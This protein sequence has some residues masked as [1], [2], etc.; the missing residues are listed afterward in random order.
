M[1]CPT[2][3]FCTLLSSLVIQ[4][5]LVLRVS[6][7]KLSPACFVTSQGETIENGP[8]GA[9]M[10]EFDELSLEL[11]ATKIGAR[12]QEEGSRS[13]FS[14]DEHPKVKLFFLPM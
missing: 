2:W 7:P 3:V 6:T 8:P 12:H 11:R 9:I 10:K 1:N 13:T 4:D 5:F 14:E